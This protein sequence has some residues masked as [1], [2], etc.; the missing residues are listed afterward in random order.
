MIEVLESNPRI[1]LVGGLL[2]NSEGSEQRGGWRVVPT[3]WRSFVR[4]L[5]LHR[6]A[7]R[8]SKLFHEF[9]L[10]KQ[11]LPNAPSRLGLCAA[12]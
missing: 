7:H 10:R 3:P 11:P 4:T 6:L 1:R 2:M 8:W 5:G 9:H 12:Q